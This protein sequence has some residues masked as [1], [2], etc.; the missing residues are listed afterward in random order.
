VLETVHAL[1]DLCQLRPLRRLA[2][3]LAL[4]LHLHAFVQAKISVLRPLKYLVSLLFVLSLAMDAFFKLLRL[5]DQW[6]NL[7]EHVILY[8]V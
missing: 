3:Q 7:V 4:Q 5:V 2:A 1:V 8:L 6:L